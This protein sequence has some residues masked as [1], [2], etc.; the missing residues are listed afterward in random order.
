MDTTQNARDVRRKALTDRI[1]GEIIEDNIIIEM[2]G[3]IIPRKP[4][5]NF[6]TYCPTKR[7]KLWHLYANLRF[8]TTILT[9]LWAG[10][11]QMVR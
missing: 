2:A 10:R 11:L 7:L 1:F 5:Q 9:N 4:I 6:L 3:R 8:T